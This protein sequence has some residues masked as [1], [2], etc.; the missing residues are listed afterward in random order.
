MSGLKRTRPKLGC[1]VIEEEE[2]EEEEKE[3]IAAPTGGIYVKLDVEDFYKNLSGNSKLD[4]NRAELSGVLRTD[5]GP[6]HHRRR[7]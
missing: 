2:K 1:K 5:L 6:L 7:H 3:I 4:K